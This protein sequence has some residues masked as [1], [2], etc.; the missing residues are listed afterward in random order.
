MPERSA[1]AGGCGGERP[2]VGERGEKMRRGGEEE[3][4]MIKCEKETNGSSHTRGPTST[5][6]RHARAPR[7]GWRVSATAAEQEYVRGAGPRTRLPALC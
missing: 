4:E 6:H 3:E 2:T 7:P 5:N 1:G